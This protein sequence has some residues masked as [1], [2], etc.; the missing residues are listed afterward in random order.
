MLETLGQG[1]AVIEAVKISP[2]LHNNVRPT[3]PITTKFY[4]YIPIVMLLT[5]LNFERIPWETLVGQNFFQYCR[6]KFFFSQTSYWPYLRN[7]WSDC[8]E[9]KRRCI[10]W[11][12]GQL[13]DLDLL[14]H[15]GFSKWGSQSI[16]AALETWLLII[17]DVIGQMCILFE[18]SAYFGDGMALI[19]TLL[20]HDLVDLGFSRSRFE[21]LCLRNGW[22]D[23]YEIKMKEID[24]ILGRLCDLEHTFELDLGFSRSNFETG[25]SLTREWEGWFN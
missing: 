18:N 1:D 19:Q 8:S 13:C 17:K 14:P 15:P 2:C 20:A 22:S 24:W 21:N 12:Q 9:T 6:C 25:R 10:D 7:G 5:W 16:W 4:S 23:W 11:R 3:Y